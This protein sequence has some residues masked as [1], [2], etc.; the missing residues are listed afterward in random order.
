MQ[1]E[2]GIRQTIKGISHG[3]ESAKKVEVSGR[4]DDYAEALKIS[5]AFARKA[6]IA[7]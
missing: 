5:R 4:L 7:I 2:N 6:S 3:G 1:P